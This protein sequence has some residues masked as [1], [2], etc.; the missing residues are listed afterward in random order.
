MSGQVI[1]LIPDEE[2][3]AVDDPTDEQLA[4]QSI[5]LISTET[6]AVDNPVDEELGG[7]VI[8]LIPT[9]TTAPVTFNT[10][11]A[12]GNI[13][14]ITEVQT[15]VQYGTFNWQN[16]P[17]PVWTVS[18]PSNEDYYAD[19]SGQAGNGWVWLLSDVF[20]ADYQGECNRS[21]YAVEWTDDNGRKARAFLRCP[22]TAFDP[23]TG[24]GLGSEETTDGDLESW[25]LPDDLLYWQEINKAAGQRDFTR[26][27]TPFVYSGS[28]ALRLDA[29][30]NDGTSFGLR[31]LNSSLIDGA[32]YYGEAWYKRSLPISLLGSA[33]FY[34]AGQEVSSVALNS[35]DMTYQRTPVY[36]NRTKATK[37]YDA[38]LPLFN[39]IVRYYL[40][41]V[42]NSQHFVDS[43][44]VKRVTSLGLKISSQQDGIEDGNWYDINAGF[45][46][47]N[48]ADI[49]IY[50]MPV[51]GSDVDK[52]AD[53]E[54]GQGIISLIPEDSTGTV[55]NPIDENIGGGVISLIPEE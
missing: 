21:H 47:H 48:V 7:G 54:I 33:K 13:S 2:A 17:A 24:G 34:L 3:T 14:L 53:E 40:E 35:Q 16:L 29:T 6:E 36:A 23:N 1:S 50:P 10:V 52:P 38:N 30:V 43:I 46:F 9:S 25:V 18:S 44:S 26:V 42:V 19:F 49:S 32:R 20:L 39:Y 28:S 27:T 41:S 55:D 45:D 5:S 37:Y 51:A 11:I 12:Q 8:S 22:L 31:Q 15:E 4:E